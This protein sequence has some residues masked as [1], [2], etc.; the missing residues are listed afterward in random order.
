MKAKSFLI[1]LLSLLSASFVCAQV[2]LDKK[3]TIF[4]VGTNSKMYSPQ[5]GI[6]T[7]TGETLIVWLNWD[8]PDTKDAI[9]ARIV[10]AKGKTVG[11]GNQI[12]KL[13]ISFTAPE[14]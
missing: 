13:K 4:P 10:N 5:F 2:Q 1:V 3:S 11:Q 6:N 12:L 8:S 9:V 7:L 14:K